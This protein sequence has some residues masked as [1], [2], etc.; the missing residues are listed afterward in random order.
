MSVRRTGS[1]DAPVE[2]VFE[3]VVS[4]PLPQ[5]YSR[6]YGPMP[7]I[8]AVRDQQGSF[9]TVGQTRVVVLADG[10][11]MHEE[12]L[13]IERP[14]RFSNR[15]TVLRGPFR[16]LVSTVEESWTFRQTGSL[17]EATWEWAL[18]PR[19]GPARLL[20]P[21]VARLWRGYARRVLEQ[22]A[23]ETSATGAR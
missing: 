17:T 7:P 11:A 14:R 10:G 4:L 15:L 18:Y 21:A 19:S 12:L 9:D 20:L 13:A 3:A 5:L 6:R 8:V 22:L 16:P 2:V 23:V 1:I